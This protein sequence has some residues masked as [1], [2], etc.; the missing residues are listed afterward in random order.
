M[1]KIYPDQKEDEVFLQCV[2]KRETDSLVKYS[3]SWKTIRIGKPIVYGGLESN[4]IPLYVAVS[5][6][7]EW[8][9]KLPHAGYQ[10]VIETGT[11]IHDWLGNAK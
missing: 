8:A 2:D 1:N 6:V 7:Q 4:I 3:Y 10:K 11:F 5:E 9:K